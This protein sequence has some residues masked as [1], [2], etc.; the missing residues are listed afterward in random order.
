MISACELPGSPWSNTLT[1]NSPRRFRNPVL[2]PIRAFEQVRRQTLDRLLARRYV[3]HDEWFHGAVEL[4]LREHGRLEVALKKDGAGA[5]VV[6]DL[7]CDNGPGLFLRRVHLAGEGEAKLR[8]ALV[9]TD[10]AALK[11]SRM[12]PPP[13]AWQAPSTTAIPP[14]PTR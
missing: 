10:R 5:V 8:I 9:D 13:V 1:T 3:R 4:N 2:R 11:R 6:I 7:T 12:N 14:A